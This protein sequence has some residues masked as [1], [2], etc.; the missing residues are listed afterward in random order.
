M[1]VK[2]KKIFSNYIMSLMRLLF[3]GKRKSRRR[4]SRRR[5]R[6]RRGRGMGPH[7]QQHNCPADQSWDPVAK[8]CMPFDRVSGTDN[9]GN[10]VIMGGR[11]RR[12]SRRRKSRRKSRRRK[13]R[14][15]KS[16]RR[17]KRRR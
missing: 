2:Y 6:K 7:A 16:R 1:I 15:R 8:R 5:T 17:R 3:G 10:K 4:R 9:S 14:R 12:R 11:R 13:S